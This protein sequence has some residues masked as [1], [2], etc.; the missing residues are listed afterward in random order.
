[1]TT[2]AAVPANLAQ[3]AAALSEATPLTR[4]VAG[5]TDFTIQLQEMA[6]EP[7]LLIALN[8]VAE[9]NQL[10][11]E[12]GA[13]WIGANLTFSELEHHETVREKFRALALAASRVGSLQIR[14]RA[15]IGGNLAN[16]S[17]CGDAIPPLMIY[18]AVIQ[19]LT[20]NGSVKDLSVP[21]VVVGPGQN[22]LA[23]NEA[24]IGIRMPFRP[25]LFQSGFVKL[26]A[27]ETVTIAKINMAA[28]FEMDPKTG[29][30]ARPR[31]ALGAVG[32]TPRFFHEA[33]AVLDGQTPASELESRFAEALTRGI[34]QSIPDRSSMP[35]KRAAVRGLAADIL[36]DISSL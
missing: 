8:K 14:N 1:M 20:A 31:V 21:E 25:G 19:V 29:R 3:V 34:E 30:I 16:A 33:E 18:D 4:L 36:S 27:R 5:G 22:G 17:P 35:Y 12:E 15:T 26:G 7:D 13:V 24:I 11:L 6:D 28:G 2:K 10:R 32:Q 23:F 9:M